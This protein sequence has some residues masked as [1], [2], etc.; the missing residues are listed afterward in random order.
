MVEP[1]YIFSRV[2]V[3]KIEHPKLCC[4]APPSPSSVRP[5][6]ALF[7][8]VLL[9]RV[10]RFRRNPFQPKVFVLP[11]AVDR[12][13]SRVIRR[14]LMVIN[15]TSGGRGQRRGKNAREGLCGAPAAYRQL[16]MFIAK[17]DPKV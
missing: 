8:V 17:A 15:G 14:G 10:L 9:L 7:V 13:P 5:P 4:G 3:G 1:P 11:T 2:S 12:E 16:K 6:K